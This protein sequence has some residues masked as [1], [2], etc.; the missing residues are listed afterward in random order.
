MLR[1]WVPS[2]ATRSARPWR[3]LPVLAL[4]GAAWFLAV[5]AQATGKAGLLHH[6]ALIEGGP[7]LWLAV[8]LFLVSWQVMV[9]AMMLPASLPTIRALAARAP[10]LLQPAFL[11]AFLGAFALVW[12]GFGLAAF[13]GDDVLH[14]VADA[15]PWLGA[16][17]WLIEASVLVLAG[18]YQLTPLKRRALAA[19]RHAPVVVGPGSARPSTAADDP[20][21]LGVGHAL[22]CLGSSW[23][24]MLLMFAEG[25]ANLWWMVALTTL[26]VYE[27]A[28]RHGQRAAAAVGALLLLSAV[29]VVARLGTLLP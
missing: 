13:L 18:A 19:C 20:V 12:S 1:A 4:V 17:P 7:S 24:L 27:T 23:A 6:H 22:V 26:M 16:R 28:G 5:V 3:P 29:V 15:T 8:P 10:D 9:A 11:L 2:T 21:R 14:H 25:F